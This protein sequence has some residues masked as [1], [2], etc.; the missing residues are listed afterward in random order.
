L[1]ITICEA[2]GAFQALLQFECCSRSVRIFLQCFVY[3]TICWKNYEYHWQPLHGYCS[4]ILYVNLLFFRIVLLSTDLSVFLILLYCCLQILQCSWYY[5][6]VVYRSFSVLDII[7]LLS[8][9]PSV[10]LM[11]LY[12]CLQIL[13]C[14]WYYCIVVYRSF[15]V[16]DVI[17]LL[18][19]DPSVFLILLYCCLQTL[20]CSWYYGQPYKLCMQFLWF[21]YLI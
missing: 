1:K 12:C 2:W 14:S 4:L 13:Q 5:C 3:Y 19:T 20:Q 11:L 16:L 15:S 18:S 7:V 21:W 17:V 8:T 10:F 6:I 9:D